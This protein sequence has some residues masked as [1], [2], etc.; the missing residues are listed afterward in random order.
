MARRVAVA[1]DDGPGGRADRGERVVVELAAADDRQP[2]IEQPDEQARHPGL[3][4][5]ALAEEDEVLAGQD[6]VLD[7]RDDRLLVA[8]D[9]REDLRRPR[10][11]SQEVGPQLLLDGPRSPADGAELARAVAAWAWRARSGST[12]CSPWLGRARTASLSVDSRSV[13]RGAGRYARIARGPRQAR[14]RRRARAPS[15]CSR[16]PVRLDLEV[17]RPAADAQGELGRDAPAEVLER[18]G[19]RRPRSRGP[20]ARAAA[21]G[22]AGRARPAGRSAPRRRAGGRRRRAAGRARPRGAT[23]RRRSRPDRRAAQRVEHVVE[24]V[25]V[26]RGGQAVADRGGPDRDPRRGAPGVG[27]QVRPTARRRAGRSSGRTGSAR[28]GRA[29]DAGPAELGGL[30]EP[31]ERLGLAGELDEA[32]PSGRKSSRARAAS[33]CRPRSAPRPTTIGTRASRSSQS[34]AAS[35]AS[36]VPARSGPMARSDGR[37]RA[38]AVGRAACRPRRSV[39][40]RSARGSN[41]AGTVRDAGRCRCRRRRRRGPTRGVDAVPRRLELR[42]LTALGRSPVELRRG[43]GRRVGSSVGAGDRRS[44]RPRACGVRSE[45]LRGPTN[46]GEPTRTGRGAPA[47]AASRCGSDAAAGRPLARPAALDA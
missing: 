28:R 16:A 4:L 44:G 2:R 45:G 29:R 34:V 17:A 11:A 26:D 42:Q 7:G 31:G 23:A 30:R 24:R 21:G 9:A 33:T 22:R 10:E 19:R 8:D 15:R 41:G 25:G 39:R 14:S 43:L 6:R 12:V 38:H 46:R 13:K 5:A 27:G 47:T 35:S 1:L 3:G 20:P 40:G 32:A 37:R 36:S 18:V